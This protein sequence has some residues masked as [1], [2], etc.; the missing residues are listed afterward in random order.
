MDVDIFTVLP[1]IFPT[2]LILWIGSLY[3][4]R[5]SVILSMGVFW[6]LFILM[7]IIMLITQIIG[8]YQ[9]HLELVDE[10]RY[11]DP[12]TFNWYI[13]MFPLI[14]IIPLFLIFAIFFKNAIMIYNIKD[15]DLSNSLNVTL[16][17]LKWE[18]D[19]DFTYIHVR[20]PKIKIKVGMIDPMRTCQIY[21]RDVKDPEV[22]KH[23]K[24]ILRTKISRNEVKPFLPMGLLFIFMGVFLPL[25]PIIMIA[26]I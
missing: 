23:F 9:N 19:R 26:M 7:F 13:Y 3:L 5:K 8:A 11:G 16:N 2:I 17:E 4:R 22:V 14:T 6:G 20:D 21:F 18:Y 12:P 15:E 24:E 1:I 25:M 10:W